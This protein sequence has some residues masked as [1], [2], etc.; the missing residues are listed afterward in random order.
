MREALQA[1]EKLNPKIEKAKEVA[2]D[3]INYK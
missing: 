2:K 1:H 3:L